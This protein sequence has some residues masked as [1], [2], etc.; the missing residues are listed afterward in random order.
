MKEKLIE[1]NENELKNFKFKGDFLFKKN[2]LYYF[3]QNFNNFMFDNEQQNFDEYI[4]DFLFVCSKVQNKPSILFLNYVPK[5][6]AKILNGTDENYNKIYQ[7]LTELKSAEN[8]NNFNQKPCVICKQEG[9]TDVLKKL[10]ET[11][12]E[13]LPQNN[14]VVFFNEPEYSHNLKEPSLDLLVS[15]A[16]S[17]KICFV[18]NFKDQLKYIDLYGKTSFEFIKDNCIKI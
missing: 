10:V 18:L 4:K 8:F 6:I 17:R 9:F 16:R 13:I 2:D 15:I 14:V 3:S 7:F 5:N 1:V 11:R 12:S